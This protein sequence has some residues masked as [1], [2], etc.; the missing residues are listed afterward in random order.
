MTSWCEGG[1]GGEGGEGGQK[2]PS[3]QHLA[4]TVKIDILVRPNCS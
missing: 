4:V 1:G 2:Q 3:L